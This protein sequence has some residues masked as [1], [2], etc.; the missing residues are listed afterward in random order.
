M[1]YDVKYIHMQR[2]ERYKKPTWMHTHEP[3]LTVCVQRMVGTLPE[4][5]PSHQHGILVPANVL[6]LPLLSICT[7]YVG[8]CCRICLLL[9]MQGQ[10]GSNT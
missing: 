1:L 7:V 3:Q 6:M 5:R 9:L 2:C 4:P 8:A 10:A